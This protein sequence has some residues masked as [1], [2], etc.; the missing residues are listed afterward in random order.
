MKREKKKKNKEKKGM[1]VSSE[2]V[3]S[4]WNLM[5]V[6]EVAHDASEAAHG[7]K[8]PLAAASNLAKLW[9]RFE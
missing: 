1:M 6:S 3:A 7:C 8:L 4:S 9:E 2:F 5:V